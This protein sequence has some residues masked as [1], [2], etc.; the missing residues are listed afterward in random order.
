MYR[1]TF[2]VLETLDEHFYENSQFG[3]HWSLNGF[4]LSDETLRGVYRDNA[5]KLLASRRT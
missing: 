5:E 3:Y 2:R 4:G 1:I